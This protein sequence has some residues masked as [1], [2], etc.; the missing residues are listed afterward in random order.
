LT[1]SLAAGLPAC[2][3]HDDPG[4]K[5]IVDGGPTAD[6][7]PAAAKRGEIQVLETR[8]YF[9]DVDDK[10]TE[11][12]SGLVQGRLLKG[13]EPRW[14]ELESQ[15][16]ACTLW[17]FK[18]ASCDQFCDGVCLGTNQCEPWPTY[19]GGGRLAVTG[20]KIDVALDPEPGLNW[21]L[22]PQ[23]PPA[24]LFTPDAEVI[25]TTT[26]GTFPAFS[27]RARGVPPLAAPVTATGKITLVPG[28]DHTFTW[29]PAS[30]DARV[31]LTIN[32]NNQGHGNPYMA[33]I[34]CDV[35]DADG[36]VV[37]PW[38]MIDA[39]P[40]TEAWYVCAGS[41]CPPSTLLRYSR[42]VAPVSDGHVELI[43]GDQISFGVVHKP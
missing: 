20:L 21:Y 16:G 10:V 4:G 41:D 25:A 26:G 33:I 6:A 34:E 3:G 18:P 11:F 24:D 9:V 40:P 22:P 43:V 32:A 30:S 2:G 1:A 36:K 37:I 14:H 7:P 15:Q 38:S 42:G 23:A 28:K 19:V 5:A 29:T 17:R 8:H 31:R 12:K 27:L 39:F 13:R 35:P